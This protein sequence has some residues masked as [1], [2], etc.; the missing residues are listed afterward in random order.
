MKSTFDSFSFGCRVNQA[1]KEEL[2][3]QLLSLGYVRSAQNPLVYIINTCAVTGKAERE[4]RQKIYQT[5]RRLPD[6]K[7]V[8]T[9]C[10]ATNWL[11]TN[12]KV[13][14]ISLLIDNQNKKYL[15]ELINRRLKLKNSK[16]KLAQVIAPLID[17]FLASKRLIV[18]IQD[19]CQRFCSFCIVPYLRGQP[20]S[21]TI[22]QI[23]S[24]INAYPSMREAILTAINT[25]AFGFDTQESFID[26][27]SAILRKTEISRLS[28]G[29]IHPWTINSE[30]IQFYS[31]FCATGRIVN[32]FHIPL[33]SGSDKMLKLM[34]RGYSSAN[35][36]EKL[37]KLD[38]IQ[39]FVFISTDI[40]VGYLEETDKDF[41]DSY[42]FLKRAPIAKFHIF[43]YWPRP[44]TAGY[45][46]SKRLTLPSAHVKHARA[47]RL[48]DLS[49]K[50]YLRFLNTHLEHTFPALL[51]E[52]RQKGLQYGLLSN[53]IPVK[54][55][56][57][58]KFV[59]EIKNVKIIDCK[60]SELFGKI[61]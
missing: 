33:Q 58:K 54:V 3:R 26:L 10:A 16:L 12:Q 47:K 61:V 53:Q 28:F 56:T 11:K 51:L 59:G 20:K 2:D 1:E 25:E 30:F 52:K 44:H 40:I 49:S 27:L 35:F 23:I 19:G 41:E 34:K 45:Y 36:L 42:Q 60:N 57:P 7:I 6:T 8:V 38:Q 24:Q 31:N 4:A 55:K 17:K 43:R 5:L 37:N 13:P 32:Y 48:S 29:S 9:G 50:K 14:G 22:S 46:L 39:P 18:K 21:K 15:A